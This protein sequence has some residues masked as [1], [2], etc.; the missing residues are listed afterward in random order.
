LL[1]GRIQ[2]VLNHRWLLREISLPPSA[3]RHL[4]EIYASAQVVGRGTRKGRMVLRLRV[5][6]ENWTR[7]LA[8]IG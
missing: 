8:R 5:T 2:A 7:L 3:G 6:P 4:K 1:L